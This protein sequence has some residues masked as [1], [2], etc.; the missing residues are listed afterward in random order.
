[1]AGRLPLGT[2]L[3]GLLH[4]AHEAYIG[5]IS[6]P[7]KAAIKEHTLAL[8]V[9]EKRIQS[10]IHEAFDLTVGPSAALLINEIDNR[11]LATEACTIMEICDFSESGWMVDG[12]PYDLMEIRHMTSH[13]AKRQFLETFY[14]IKGEG[15]VQN[16]DL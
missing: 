13:M 3:A 5:D 2:R 9:I 4:D 15:N 10:V 11:V 1:M 12:E 7:L 8:D 16:H 14:A 6:R